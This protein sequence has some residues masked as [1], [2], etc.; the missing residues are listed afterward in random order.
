MQVLIN[1][2]SVDLATEEKPALGDVVAQAEK[3]ASEHGKVIIQITVNGELITSQDEDLR[4]FDEC[5]DSDKI[6]MLMDSPRNIIVAA[7]K[8]ADGDIPE[9]VDNLKS[10]AAHLQTGSRQAAFSLFSQC[11][12]QWKQVINLFRIAESVIGVDAKELVIEGRTLDKVQTELLEL[13]VETKKSMQEDDA[14]TLSDLLEYELA[15]NV[16]QHR[17]IIRHLISIANDSCTEDEE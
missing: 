7:L 4:R 3:F 8:E 17:N 14:V 15:P 11:I 2:E 13:L 9:I 1:E 12:E 5:Q 6:D 10:V 16:E